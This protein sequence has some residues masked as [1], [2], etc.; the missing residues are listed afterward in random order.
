[1]GLEQLIGEEKIRARSHA[2]WELE[3]YPEGRAHEHWLRAIAELTAE[4]ERAWLAIAEE[5]ERTEF[6][7]PRPEVREAPQRVQAGRCDP[8]ALKKAA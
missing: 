7:M 4:L 1:M 8:G 2:I 6:V 5:R 3:G